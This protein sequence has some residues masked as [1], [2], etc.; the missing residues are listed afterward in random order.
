LFKNNLIKLKYFIFLEMNSITMYFGVFCFLI[1]CNFAN[2]A[3][4]P[5]CTPEGEKTLLNCMANFFEHY[6]VTLGKTVTLE[7]YYEAIHSAGYISDDVSQYLNISCQWY[8]QRTECLGEHEPCMNA[9]TLVKVF[10]LA[11]KDLAYEQIFDYQTHQ[12]RCGEGF[13][14]VL[15]ITQKNHNCIESVNSVSCVMEVD[16]YESV[17]CE[18]LSRAT[19]CT[20]K[21]YAKHCG[22]KAGS[23][24]CSQLKSGYNAIRPDCVKVMPEC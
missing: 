23:L 24:Y 22:A 1:L 11:D 17:T 6:G 8:D 19:E 5:T 3:D 16:S 14:E 13:E 18:I 21:A 4:K 7:K 2:A 10:E 20:R 9:D 15:N 12:Y